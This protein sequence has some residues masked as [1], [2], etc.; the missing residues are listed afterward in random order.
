M[1]EPL[2][3]LAW[4][5]AP[6][7][8]AAVGV[9]ATLGLTSWQIGQEWRIRRR[10]RERGQAVLI[11]GWHLTDERVTDAGDVGWTLFAIANR[12]NEPIYDVVATLV[13]IQG[14]GPRTGEEWIRVATQAHAPLPLGRA[15]GAVG[16]GEW[17]LRVRAGWHVV[18]G[19]VGCEIGFTDAAGKRWIRRANGELT[20][21]PANA[22]DY[23]GIGR[24]VDYQVPERATSL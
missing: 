5:D 23:Y 15:F 20:A 4:G 6:S 11:S 10:E 18:L 12:S 22:I 16:P 21:I 7:W 17:I 1:I 3:L 13:Y 9:S 24:P 8:V 14:T 19:R 2:W